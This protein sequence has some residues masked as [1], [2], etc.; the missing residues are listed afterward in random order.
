MMIMNDSS[1]TT[2]TANGSSTTSS[3]WKRRN[4][5]YSKFNIIVIVYHTITCVIVLR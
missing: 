4:L 1:S 2:I 3:N 5:E